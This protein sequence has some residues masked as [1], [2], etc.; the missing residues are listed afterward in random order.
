MIYE[1]YCIYCKEKVFKSVKINRQITITNN[2]MVR[3]QIAV[4]VKVVGKLALRV[5]VICGNRNLT[6]IL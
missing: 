3:S 2:E 1:T 5:S 6:A 4:R